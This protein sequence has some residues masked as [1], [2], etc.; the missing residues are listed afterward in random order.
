M[1]PLKNI[2]AYTTDGAP[3]M[4]GRYKGFIAHLKKAV[5][6]VFYIHCVIHRQ[7]LVAKKLSRRLHDA[8]NVVIEEVNHIKSNFFRDG[9]FRILQ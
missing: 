3:S 4:R 8:L 9:L 2:I 1:I 5:P 6:K 7:N